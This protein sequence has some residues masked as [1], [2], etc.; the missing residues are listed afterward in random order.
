VKLIRFYCENICSG[1]TE[2]DAVES[3]H[4]L[5]VMRLGV[6]SEIELFDGKGALAKGVVCEAK[7]KSVRVEVENIEKTAPRTEKRVIIAASVA[8]GQR[9][10]WMIS[11]CTEL[12][13]DCIVP[14]IFERTVKQATGISYINRCNKLAISAAK[15]SSRLLLPIITK[16]LDINEC[17]DYINK[18]YSNATI[19]FGGFGKESS[20]IVS[21]S[22]EISDVAAFIGPEGGITADEE[23]KLGEF[24]AVKVRLTDTILRIETASVAFASILCTFRDDING[25]GVR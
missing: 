8:K 1:V 9:F 10:D 15:Q 16:P 17:L 11:K 14:V 23:K 13:V 18:E 5:H 24:G 6:G 2:L 12:G 20:G 7:R 19:V 3:H 25:Q 22:N 21:L 4:L